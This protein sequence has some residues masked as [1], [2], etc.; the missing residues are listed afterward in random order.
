MGSLMFSIVYG[1][2]VSL[3]GLVGLVEVGW[4]CGA[5]TM[6]IGVPF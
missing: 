6:T 2:P 5:N 1:K 3:V 4:V